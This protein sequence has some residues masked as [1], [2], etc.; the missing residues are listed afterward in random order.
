MA[1][2][3]ANR[4]SQLY[5]LDLTF[6]VFKPEGVM[7][8]LT[9]LTKKRKIGAALKELVCSKRMDAYVSWTA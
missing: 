9:S 3:V 6:K 2:V 4:S 1:L 8:K 7:F 5:A